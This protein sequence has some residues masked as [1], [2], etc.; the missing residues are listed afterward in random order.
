MRG[1]PH[2]S[3]IL[4][5]IGRLWEFGY[6]GVFY[7]GP[8]LENKSQIKIQLNDNESQNNDRNENN[9]DQNT[10]KRWLS[11]K[12]KFKEEEFVYNNTVYANYANVNNGV[13]L[14]INM[15]F[16]STGYTL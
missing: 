5:G 8:D 15:N 11:E 3:E 10:E 1:Y 14:W 16:R 6:R 4:S 2:K 13:K 12:D 9:D 7:I